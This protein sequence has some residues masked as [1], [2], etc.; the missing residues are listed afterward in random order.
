MAYKVY[1]T[2]NIGPTA[3]DKKDLAEVGAELI[4]PD[5]ESE[6]DLIRI[7][8]SPDVVALLIGPNAHV[9]KRVIDAIPNLKILSRL[10][11]GYD[12]IDVKAATARGVPVSL[13]LDYCLT[14][15]AD[16]AMAF[17]LALARQIV[18]ISEM[19]KSGHWLNISSLRAKIFRLSETTLGIFGLGRIGSTL[20]VRAKAFGMRIIACDPYRSETYAKKRGAELVDFNRLLAESDFLSV[21]CPLTEETTRK[22]NLEAFKKMKRT[23]YLINNARGAIVD[24]RALLKRV[25]CTRVTLIFLLVNILVN[26]F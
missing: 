12:N 4:L 15:V 3:Q 17:I 25:W 1:L 7:C 8:S 10:G 20:A 23:A 18:P 11:I 13:V 22:F 6:E 9:T 24:E 26:E 21:H 5:G 16:H 14:E 2:F 19:V